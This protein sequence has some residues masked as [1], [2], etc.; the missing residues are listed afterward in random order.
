MT[1]IMPADRD[2]LRAKQVRQGVARLD[3]AYDRFV[4]RF[5]ARYGIAPLT[6]GL[7][8]IDKPRR[9]GKTPR[10]AVVLERSS[11]YRSFLKSPFN[12]DKTKQREIAH[13]LTGTVASR[14]LCEQFGVP[15]RLRGGALTAEEIFVCFE[16]F[17]KVAKDEVHDLTAEAERDRFESSLGIGDQFWCT[18]RFS[19]PPIVFVHTEEQAQALRNSPLRDTWADTYYELAK[20]HDEFG[21]LVR[22][23]I[24][25]MVDSKE[26]FEN[27]YEGNWYYYFK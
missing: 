18:Q 17:E 16:D 3:P 2:Y 8:S 5:H 4:E 27:H 25:I 24:A 13:L 6:I 12:Y 19:G 23:E 20:P 9:E 26:N 10:L 1:F 21:Y 22:A 7:D 15:A 11:E 14:T